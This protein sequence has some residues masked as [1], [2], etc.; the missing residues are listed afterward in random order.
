M[1]HP[2]ERVGRRRRRHRSCGATTGRDHLSD[3]FRGWLGGLRRAPAASSRGC[4]RRPSTRTSA[5]SPSRGRRPR[6]RGAAT[7]ARAGSALVGHGPG[8]PGRVAHPRRRREPLPRVRGHD[9]RP[10]CTASSTV[11]SPGTPFDGN[12]YEATDLPHVPSTLVDA[13]GELERSEVAKARRSVPTCTT[14]SSNTAKQ[15]WAAFNRVVT[16]WER[17]R[18]FEQF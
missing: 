9:R 11:S 16:D 2:L 7:T 13:I 6:S 14:T 4:S 10:A 1:P 8:L 5:T 15:E 12:A 18:N 17:R 3:V